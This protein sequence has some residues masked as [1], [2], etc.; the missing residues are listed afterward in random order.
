M[1]KKRGLKGE[2]NSSISAD[3]HMAK[4]SERNPLHLRFLFRICACRLLWAALGIIG[5][6]CL[7]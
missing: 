6:A 2:T 3:V 1:R 4:S 5:L 7:P